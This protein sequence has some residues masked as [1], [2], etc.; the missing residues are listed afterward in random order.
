ME[1][2]T[3]VNEFW[4]HFDNIIKSVT[5]LLIHLNVPCHKLLNFLF[6]NFQNDFGETIILHDF[7]DLDLVEFEGFAITINQKSEKV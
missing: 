1:V 2:S 7:Q 6:V 5:I 3:I 4:L